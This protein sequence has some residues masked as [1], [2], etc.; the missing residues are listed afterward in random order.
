MNKIDKFLDI[1]SKVLLFF[2]VA[3]ILTLIV[4]NAFGVPQKMTAK[5]T[6]HHIESIQSIDATDEDYILF[7]PEYVDSIVFVDDSARGCYYANVHYLG[8]HILYTSYTEGESLVEQ[9][10]YIYSNYEE[11]SIALEEALGS[12][13]DNSEI[14]IVNDSIEV[15]SLWY[16]K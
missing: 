13:T 7:F 9:L 8:S 16:I 6:K 15:L 10:D 12:I 3:S 14:I 2:V 11:D 1:L 4:L 5:H